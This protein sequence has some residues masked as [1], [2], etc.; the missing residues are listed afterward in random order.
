MAKRESTPS[1]AAFEERAREFLKTQRRILSD[2]ERSLKNARHFIELAGRSL[3]QEPEDTIQMMEQ[4]REIDLLRHV[5]HHFEEFEAVIAMLPPALVQ[6]DPTLPD[7]A[8]QAE[9]KSM[10]T[11]YETLVHEA[12]SQAADMERILSALQQPH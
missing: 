3:E 4:I 12:E 10:R 1:V 6:G 7:T 9:M 8:P 5:S 2:F 11:R